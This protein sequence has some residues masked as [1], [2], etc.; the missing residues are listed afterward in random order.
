MRK[1]VTLLTIAILATLSVGLAF[2]A[3]GTSSGDP[4]VLVNYFTNANTAGAP[5]GT[6]QVTNQGASGAT[7]CANIYVFYPD[8]ELAEC[9]SC[10]VTPNGL[11]TLSI[12]SSLTSNLLTSTPLPTGTVTI[13]SSAGPSC[14]PT[15]I[16]PNSAIDAWGTH[17]LSPTTGGYVITET[18]FLTSSLSTAEIKSL[19][20]NCTAIVDVGSGHGICTCGSGS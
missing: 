17:I 2:G 14:N 6:V 15:S 18:Q 19:E 4:A 16:S 8:Q 1:Q 12:D 5:D 10:A 20:T 7:V 3:T 11:L 9:C 13:V